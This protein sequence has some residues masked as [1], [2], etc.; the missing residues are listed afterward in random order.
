MTTRATLVGY[1]EDIIDRDDLTTR[2][3][4][5]FNT[6]M[7]QVARKYDFRILMDEDTS[8]PTVASQV[9]YTLP[10]NTHRIYKIIYE[11]G[12]NSIVLR[13]LSISEFD[14]RYPYPSADGDSEPTCYCRRNETT[15]D[16][17]TPPAAVKTL[18]IYRS[19]HPTLF[20][21]DNSEPDYLYMDDVLVS[22]VI[23]EIYRQL[24]LTDDYIV[25]QKEFKQQLKEAY[26][27]DQESPN[28]IEFAR[29]FGASAVLKGDYWS[30]P[31]YK[32]Y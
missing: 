29:G 3:Q 32:G 18:R 17:Y 25:W 26:D 7:N 28:L 16:L 15:I 31:F 30:N 8:V 20:S 22:G 1:V 19:K 9:T 27:R 4:T 13:E 6:V 14:R 23:A 2:V 12:S 11:D 10:T 21:A 5:A 24:D